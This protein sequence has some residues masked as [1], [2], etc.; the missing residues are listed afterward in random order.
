VT[1]ASTEVK[2][3]QDVGA[4]GLFCQDSDVGQTG[5]SSEIGNRYCHFPFIARQVWARHFHKVSGKSDDIM[6]RTP[7]IL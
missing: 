2:I 6:H 4:L 7:L 3:N 5:G 1:P